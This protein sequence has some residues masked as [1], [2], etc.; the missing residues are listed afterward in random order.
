M[1]TIIEIE[2]KKEDVLRGIE[3]APRFNV[4]VEVKGHHPDGLVTL[5]FTGDVPNLEQ[6]VEHEKP[7]D[8]F[9]AYMIV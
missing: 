7:G 5:R 8:E 9:E 2:F 6:L 1:Q 3:L 4:F